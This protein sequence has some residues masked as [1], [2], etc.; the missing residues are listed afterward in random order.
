M[1]TP[2]VALLT[3]LLLLGAGPATAAQ[4]T[5]SARLTSLAETGHA[6][7]AYHLGMLSQTGTGVPRDPKRAFAWF[8]KAADAGDP[9]GAY[10]V[11]CFYAGQGAGVVADDPD[12]AL[13][14][15]LVAA[16][17]GYA[18]AQY[19]VGAHFAQRKR[20]A[21]ALAWFRLA[22]AQGYPMGLYAVAS[23]AARPE[24]DTGN[25]A[26]AYVHFKLSKLVTE[27]RIS[28]AAQASLDELAKRLTPSER[29]KAEEAVRAY[30]PQPTDLTQKALSGVEAAE[31]LAR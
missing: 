12:K 15:K 5:L 17:A 10:K 21:E 1:M 25:P 29:A 2:P 4:P 8:T 24:T 13:R 19:D 26:D 9:L 3:A 6:E 31:K 30:R 27:G 7:A 16:K 22:A 18:L 23:L 11:G 14:Y 28:P 20:F